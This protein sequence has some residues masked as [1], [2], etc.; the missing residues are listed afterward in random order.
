MVSALP[1][2]SPGLLPLFQQTLTLPPPPP[3]QADKL[4]T[5]QELERRQAKYVGT[6][7]ADVSSWEWRTNIYRD[8]Y[9]SIVGHAPLVS[10]I[11]LAENEP[12]SKVRFALIQVCYLVAA[13]R[14]R[15]G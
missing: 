7:H 11:A 13:C 12:S 15:A 6:G 5:A 1:Q 14:R 10:W 8:T 3:K 2:A 4:R 9:A